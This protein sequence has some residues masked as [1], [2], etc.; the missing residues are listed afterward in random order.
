M[1]ILQ[2]HIALE[3][4]IGFIFIFNSHEVLC[5]GWLIEFNYLIAS[6]GATI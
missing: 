5:A 1:K 6:M 4:T 3:N 2:T